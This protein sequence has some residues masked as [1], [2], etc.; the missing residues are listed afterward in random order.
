MQDHDLWLRHKWGLSRYGYIRQTKGARRLLHRLILGL[1]TE[2]GSVSTF[3][4][5]CQVDHINGDVLN[6]T[7]ANL[8]VCTGN[9]NKKNRRFKMPGT[10]SKYRGVFFE[11]ANSSWRVQIST[12]GHTKKHIGCF[13]LP[14]LAAKAYDDAAKEHFGEFANLNFKTIEDYEKA[15][16]DESLIAH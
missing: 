10:S 12:G 9:E 6:N 16:Q 11:K 13:K 4:Q 3:S 8:R 5:E 1:D 2:D 7:R 14:V 15:L